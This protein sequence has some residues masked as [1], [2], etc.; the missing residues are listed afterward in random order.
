MF[1]SQSFDISLALLYLLLQRLVKVLQIF[2]V[3]LLKFR[4]S[5]TDGMKIYGICNSL[6]IWCFLFDLGENVVVIDGVFKKIS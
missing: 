6:I 2:T 3:I 1:L 4:Y 5:G